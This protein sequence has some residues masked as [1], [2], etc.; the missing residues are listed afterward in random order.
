MVKNNLQTGERTPSDLGDALRSRRNELGLTMQYVADLAG[1]SVGFISQVERGLTSPSLASLASLA[2]VLN[3][4]ITSFLK[5]PPTSGQT[6]HKVNRLAYS[7]SGADVSYERLSTSFPD[8]KLHSVIVHE[9]PGHRIEPMSHRGEEMFYIID[10]EITVEIEGE[11]EV[12]R[13]GDSIH[14]DSRRVHSIWNHSARPASL[15]WCG[16][17]DIF[18]DAPAPIHKEVASP[19]AAEIATGDRT[20]D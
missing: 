5:P 1:L 14:F 8:S 11:A 4:E 20:N 2:E 10:G 7:V 6:T 12:L 17:M 19:E 13:K 15:L 3:T 18:G 16:T 9:P